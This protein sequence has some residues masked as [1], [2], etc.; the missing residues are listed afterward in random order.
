MRGGFV[1]SH[2]E[3]AEHFTPT[4]K[5]LVVGGSM[6]CM[7]A[8]TR[9]EVCGSGARHW[10]RMP[11]LFAEGGLPEGVVGPS[12]RVDL[13]REPLP[14]VKIEEARSAPSPFWLGVVIA[15][16]A[17]VIFLFMCFGGYR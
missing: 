16:G 11:L 3:A 4:A 13:N 15:L 10:E 2:P 9:A 8:R 5:E 1:C 7:D 17:I 12:R 14:P 6:T